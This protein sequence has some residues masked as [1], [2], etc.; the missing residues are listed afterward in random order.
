[1]KELIISKTAI[2]NVTTES[3]PPRIATTKIA[4]KISG[5]IKLFYIFYIAGISSE[6][7]VNTELYKVLLISKE[8][9]RSV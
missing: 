5:E 1:M 3:V 6:K 2:I 7:G 4:V 8:S 9:N